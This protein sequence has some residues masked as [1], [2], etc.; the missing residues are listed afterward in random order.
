ML[1]ASVGG[2]CSL[3]IFNHPLILFQQLCRTKI[4]SIA[5]LAYSSTGGMNIIEVGFL[6]AYSQLCRT[7]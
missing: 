6:L 4:L 3:N 1:H 5:C 7:I 2:D